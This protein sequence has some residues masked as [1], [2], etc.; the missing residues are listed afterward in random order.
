MGK[1]WWISLLTFLHDSNCDRYG[2][3]MTH[4]TDN[5]NAKLFYAILCLEKYS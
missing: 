1:L 4:N 3:L 2:K 5:C